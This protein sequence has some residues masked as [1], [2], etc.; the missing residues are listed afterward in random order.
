MTITYIVKNNIYINM[1]NRCTNKCSFCIRNNADG[2]YG[3]DSL[4]LE[5]EPT[6]KE[7][8]E[9]FLKYDMK[10]FD[11]IVF[12]GY[13]EPTLRLKELIEISRELKSLYT[14]KIRLNTNGQANLFYKRDITPMFENLID[15]VS[16]SLNS[17]DSKS[18][19]EICNSVFGLQAL[20]GVI[21]FGVACKKYVPKVVF[22]VVRQSLN[23]D[24][25][26][27]CDIIAQDA[28][29]ELVVRELIS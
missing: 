12:C 6:V 2:A 5:R 10:M 22:T 26:K 29:I 20:Q 11:E 23:E 13:G 17:P 21:D 19:D 25:L 14:N 8:V 16:I 1:T 28:G 24:E 27:K 9:D 7:V 4:W 18:Y 15:S 3:S